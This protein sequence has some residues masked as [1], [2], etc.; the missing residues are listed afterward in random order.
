MKESGWQEGS[1]YLT[2]KEACEYAQICRTTL[3]RLIDEYE[4]ESFKAGGKRL[5]SRESLDSWM[6]KEA[7][8]KGADVE[9]SEQES[10]ELIEKLIKKM[11][12]V[13]SRKKRKRIKRRG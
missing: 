5:I 3:Y 6:R 11:K 13:P 7:S 9:L 8:R 2:I 4:I 1:P 10:D 12:M